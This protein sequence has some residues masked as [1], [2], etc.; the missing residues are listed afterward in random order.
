VMRH[1]SRQGELVSE[2]VEGDS[3][4]VVLPPLSC[5]LVEAT[6][7]ASGDHRTASG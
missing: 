5:V 7:S 6:K 3:V 4:D 1:L 2:A